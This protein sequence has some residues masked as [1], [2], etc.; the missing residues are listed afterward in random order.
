M[1][2]AKPQD[3]VRL[4]PGQVLFR[5]GEPKRRLYEVLS[6]SIGLTPGQ[7]GQAGIQGYALAGT[8]LGL[9][10]LDRHL[11][12]AQ[13]LTTTEVRSLPLAAVQDLS[14]QSA[15]WAERI[16]AA[17]EREFGQ[18][19]AQAAGEDERTAVQK[20]ASFLVAVSSVNRSA[21]G[22][23]FVVT[24]GLTSGVLADY[25]G[26]SIEDLSAALVHLHRLGFVSPARAGG[27]RLLDVAGLEAC[28]DGRT[29]SITV[30]A[31]S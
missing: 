25:L 1:P 21:C 9:G 11:E 10:F 20:L 28:A 15:D 5:A 31:H 29:G 4:S 27:L 7:P 18:L 2:E 19:R 6:G 23:P 26:L 3:V 12:T 14:T 22:D 17:A 13:A 24:D 30:T 16:R 8:I